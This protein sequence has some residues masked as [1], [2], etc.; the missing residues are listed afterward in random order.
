MKRT[1]FIS[2]EMSVKYFDRLFFKV[3]EQ[4]FQWFVFQ[5][6]R[7]HVS[8]MDFVK[9]AKFL[10]KYLLVVFDDSMVLMENDSACGFT[11]I[12][13]KGL[14]SSTHTQKHTQTHTHTHNTHLHIY[15]Q[16]NNKP[17]DEC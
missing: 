1:F 11:F 16:E 12:R 5:R 10:F 13:K 17:E 3:F 7:Y 14:D 6:R 9:F 4:M 8:F 15:K 2:I